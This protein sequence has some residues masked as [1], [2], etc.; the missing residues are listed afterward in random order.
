[1]AKLTDLLKSRGKAK[2]TELLPATDAHTRVYAVGDIHGRLDLVTAMMKAIKKDAKSFDGETQLV[3]LGDYVDRGPDSAKI[4]DLIMNG[5]LPCDIQ[6]C[7]RG[8]HEDAMVGFAEGTSASRNWLHYGGID[9]LASYGVDVNK[10]IHEDDDPTPHLRKAMK[11]AVPKMH[12]SFLSGLPVSHINGDYFFVH[13]GVRPKVP[14]PAQNT[15]DMMWI[16]D[17]FLKHKKPFEQFIVHGHTITPGPDVQPN[18]IG[19]DTGAYKTGT[20][21]CLVLEDTQKRFLTCNA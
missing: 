5:P 4:V 10:Y 9:T 21:T 14:L 12:L 11:Q 16:R 2:A 13:A 8:N 3:L 6:I 15:N 18:R 7:L 19:I 20:L 1:M 17:D